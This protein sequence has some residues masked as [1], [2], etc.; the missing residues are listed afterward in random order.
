[1]G[2][3]VCNFGVEVW[4]LCSV[5][6]STATTSR[7]SAPRLVMLLQEQRVL[8]SYTQVYSVIYDSGSVPD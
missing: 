4:G 5:G 8:S 1:M 2:F 3:E 7:G 6:A